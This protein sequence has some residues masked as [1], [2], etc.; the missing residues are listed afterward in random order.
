MTIQNKI[1][2]CGKVWVQKSIF[3]EGLAQG[4][5]ITNRAQFS[6]KYINKLIQIRREL[7]TFSPDEHFYI[8]TPHS[9]FGLSDW[10]IWTD[11]VAE[12]VQQCALFLV[13]ATKDIKTVL[14]QKIPQ[15]SYR[16]C[17]SCP[18]VLED[19]KKQFFSSLSLKNSK[20][21]CEMFRQIMQVL[22]TWC[23]FQYTS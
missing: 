6:F 4:M 19:L 21:I 14:D 20:N 3:S 23:E 11:F 5:S 16:R 9:G 10:P 22:I 12:N 7:E 18:S 1:L 13:R 15:K 2:L 8:S 17:K